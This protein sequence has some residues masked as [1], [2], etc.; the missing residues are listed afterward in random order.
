MMTDVD[1]PSP[2]D[3]RT[4]SGLL[5]ALLV[6]LAAGFLSGLFGVGGGILVVPALVLLL[7]LPQRRAHGTSLAAVLPIALASLVSY[8]TS[9]SIDWWVSLFLAIGAIFGAVVGT[10]L[11][12]VLPHRALGVGFALLLLVTGIRMFVP[13]GAE[14]RAPLTA[15][16]VVLLIVVGLAIGAL[17]GLF[18]VGGGVVLVPVLVVFW[19]M[20]PVIAKGT[21]L[22]V[23]VPTAI[24]GTWR[25]RKKRNADLRIATIVGLSGIVSAVLG[26]EVAHNLDDDL[27]NVLFAI[28]LVI[29]AAKLLWEL[30]RAEEH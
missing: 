1:M 12:Q 13:L 23:V 17:A 8:A 2:V 16:T 7:H 29:V 14:G 5:R 21:S 15:L 4:R 22:A 26:S 11:L 19:S 20:A 3:V 18:G 30:R 9:G 10:H 27:A 6:G 25:N 24:V 28:L